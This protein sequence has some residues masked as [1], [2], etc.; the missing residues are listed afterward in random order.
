MFSL[1]VD[2]DIKLSL[3]EERHAEALFAV[4]DANRAYLREWMPWLDTTNSPDD[5]KQFIK[6]SLE[7]F[8]ANNGSQTVLVFQGKLVGGMGFH[9]YDWD[10]RS[11]SLGYWLAADHQGK[12][13][14][15]R[16]CRFLVNYAFTELK[17]NRVEIRCAVENHRSCAI[18]ER[19][20]F[21]KEGTLRQA[22]W[23]YDHY[24]NH[25]VYSVLAGEWEG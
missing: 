2:D 13:I 10:N 4:I 12:G 22:E 20:G 23:L 3:L 1:T 25:V 5:L 11:T 17:L 18:P 16:A 6:T 7:Q 8:V 9:R 24:V 21:K 14:V 19:L 15:T